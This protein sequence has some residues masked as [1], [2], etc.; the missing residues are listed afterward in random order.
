MAV[1]RRQ[2][3]VR[4]I[5]IGNQVL[6]LA[7]HGTLVLPVQQV[8]NIT[9]LVAFAGIA[10]AI[11][12]VIVVVA[13]GPA[14][15]DHVILHLEDIEGNLAHKPLCDRKVGYGAAEGN[16]SIG[17][18]LFS[19]DYKGT[20]PNAQS[21][22]GIRLEGDSEGLTLGAKMWTVFE[23]S[24]GRSLDGLGLERGH[25]LKRVGLKELLLWCRRCM[26]RLL[27]LLLRCWLL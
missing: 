27:L 11:V 21:L 23:N 16:I 9:A 18:I 13:K 6:L 5:K 17:G 14:L 15:H 22:V 24:W 4:E 10:L 7:G 25:L 12:I 8:V 2:L 19:I 20:E 26:N 3:G 1:L